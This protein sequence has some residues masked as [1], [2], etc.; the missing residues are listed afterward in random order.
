MA[1]NR[2]FKTEE[3]VRTY[4]V[5]SSE[6]D[7]ANGIVIDTKLRKEI[8]TSE[9]RGRIPIGGFVEQYEFADMKGGVWFCTISNKR[10]LRNTI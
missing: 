6:K 10:K 2:L 4:F 5:Y 3:D 7:R 9:Y 8:L 1:D